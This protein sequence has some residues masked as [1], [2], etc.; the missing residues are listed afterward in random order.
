MTQKCSII[1]KKIN[2]KK[3]L[4]KIRLKKNIRSC[5]FCVMVEA[6]L[7][8]GHTPLDMRVIVPLYSLSTLSV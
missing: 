1:R 8:Y 3:V 4:N 2:L 7:T 5:V 6:P